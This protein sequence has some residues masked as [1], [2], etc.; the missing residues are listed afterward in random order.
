MNT[1]GIAGQ[2]SRLIFL[3]G[4]IR[5]IWRSMLLLCHIGL[6]RRRAQV[7]VRARFALAVRGE[8]HLRAVVEGQSVPSDYCGLILEG[9]RLLRTRPAW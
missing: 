5:V 3:K 9:K 6:R 4:T 7:G 1:G 8:I 2:E